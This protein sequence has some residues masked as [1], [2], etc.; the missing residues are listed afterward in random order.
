[1]AEPE[2]RF[3][4]SVRFKLLLVSLTLMVIP[5]AGY[6]YIEETESFLRRA[7]EN[8]LLGTAQAIATVLHN[9]HELFERVIQLKDTLSSPGNLYVHRLESPIQL[10]GYTEDWAELADR[11]EHFGPEYRLQGAEDQPADSLSFDYLAGTY[12]GYLYVLLQVTDDRV[13]YR[14]ANSRR[15]DRNDH[16]EIVLEEP[17]GTLARYLLATFSPGWVN[18]HRMPDDSTQPYPLRPEVRIKGEWQET[19]NGYAVEIRIP[20]SMLSRRLLPP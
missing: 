16:L 13:V 8:V 14:S 4:H 11:A 9:R 7:Q 20:E 17:G 2:R 1:M 19:E 5:W 3:Y 6:R 10:D 18:A 15:L 12:R